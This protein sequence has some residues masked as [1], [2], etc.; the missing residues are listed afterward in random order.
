MAIDSPCINVCRIDPAANVCIGCYRSI[1]EITRWRGY[2]DGERKRVL[3]ALPLRKRAVMQAQQAQQ[4]Q[5][6]PDARGA[7]ASG[8]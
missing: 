8:S 7:T 3:A 2:S 4:Q 1:D 5:A 6:H